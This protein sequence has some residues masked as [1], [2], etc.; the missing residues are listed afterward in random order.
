[1]STLM[2]ATDAGALNNVPRKM[3]EVGGSCKDP[4]PVKDS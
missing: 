2:G 3:C 1:M 4:N